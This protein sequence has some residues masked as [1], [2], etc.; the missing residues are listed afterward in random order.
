MHHVE[1]FK[2]TLFSEAPVKQHVMHFFEPKI[3]ESGR[4]RTHMSEAIKDVSKSA[5][6]YVGMDYDL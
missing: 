5:L 3:R 2:P 6:N 4:A 1:L